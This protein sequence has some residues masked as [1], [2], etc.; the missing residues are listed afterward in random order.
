MYIY[1]DFLYYMIIYK[2]INNDDF[3]IVNLNDSYI[4]LYNKLNEDSVSGKHAI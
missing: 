2:E 4:Y 3:N 1:D